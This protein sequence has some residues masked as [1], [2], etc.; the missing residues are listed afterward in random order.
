MNTSIKNKILIPTLTLMI[1]GLGVLA[2]VSYTKSKNALQTVIY[3]QIHQTTDATAKVMMTWSRDRELDLKTWSHDKTYSTA[4]KDSFVGKA[5]RK[6]ASEQLEDLVKEYGYFEN[7]A[8]ADENGDLVASADPSHI[9]KVNV[10][11]IDFFKTAIKGGK[12]IEKVMK[13]PATGRPIMIFAAP[14]KDKDTIPGILLAVVSLDAFSR[15]FIDPIKVGKEGYAYLM[16][17]K[18][19][20]LAYPDKSKIYTL[21]LSKFDFGKQMLA[22]KKGMLEYSFEGRDKIIMYQAIEQLGCV[23]VVTAST[24]ELFAPVASMGKVN[25]SVAFVVLLA[26]VAVI[27]LV[28]GTVVKPV[29]RVVAGL[30]DA[31]EG[32]GDLTKR[33]DVKSRDEIGS[34]ARWFNTFVKKLQGI[35]AEIAENSEKLNT[36]SSD[37]LA[38]SKEMSEGADKMSSK[39]ST[40]AAAAEEMSSNMSSVAAAAE[41]SSTN[42]GM[43]SAAAEEMTSTINEIAQNTEKTR[44]SSNQAV[45]RTKK[46]SE[47]INSLSK[48]AQEI[49]R[50]VETI[51]DISEQ[52]NLLALNATIEAARAGEAGKGFAVVAGEIKELARQTAEATLEIKQKIESIQGSTHQTVSEIEEI[53]VEI[54]N[55]NEMID[56]VAA[57]V[58]EQS[59][60]TREIAF[61]VN[62]AAQGIQ[63]VTENVTQSSIVANEISKDIADVNQAA[64]EMSNNS[65]QVNTSAKDLSLL[66]GALKKLV[67]QFKI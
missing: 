50:V 67:D 10:S 14:I 18:G 57:A 54:N 26:A 52:T 46:A 51:N 21:D 49:G 15:E 30:K 6:A 4:L 40:V 65:S 59:S 29:N 12:A 35:I 28:T 11:G 42:I 64:Y 55:V 2:L 20:V 43:V 47:N 39:S 23:L 19:M 17:E 61:N 27:W 5:A 53:A 56:T 38:I 7:I 31:A 16:D 25:A 9:G 48:S 58:E 24:Q 13:S 34:L 33:L 62:Q 44:N 32:E 45:S 22:Q 60:T 66:S 3:D 8:V 1:I 37:L 63:E 36:S 41:Q